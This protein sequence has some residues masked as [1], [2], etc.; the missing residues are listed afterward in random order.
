MKAR[1]WVVGVPVRGTVDDLEAAMTRY[2]VDEVILSS[3]SIN[4]SVEQR[5][6][7]VCQRLDRPVRR[8]QM[9]IT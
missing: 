1:R 5:V 7:D 6:R 2:K 4:G 8:V 9:D 3:A